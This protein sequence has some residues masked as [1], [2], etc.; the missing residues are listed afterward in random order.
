MTNYV[1]DW[2][3]CVA[4]RRATVERLNL[5]ARRHLNSS[6]VQRPNSRGAS[7]EAGGL[8]QGCITAFALTHRGAR[9]SGSFN[10]KPQASPSFSGLAQSRARGDACGLPLNE[11]RKTGYAPLNQPVTRSTPM[12][13]KMATAGMIGARMRMSLQ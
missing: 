10:G 6:T 8:N 12:A 7:A 13:A 1:I 11:P 9:R 3:G 5:I 4:D 2:P